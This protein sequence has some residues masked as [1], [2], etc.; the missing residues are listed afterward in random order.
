[1]DVPSASPDDGAVSD[2]L[3]HRDALDE[4]F[5]L[6]DAD[7]DGVLVVSDFILVRAHCERTRPTER[8]PSLTSS[9]SECMLV[10]LAVAHPTPIP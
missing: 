5:Q 6:V 9:V 3:V 2:S 4:V 1:M 10:S 7:N 8:P